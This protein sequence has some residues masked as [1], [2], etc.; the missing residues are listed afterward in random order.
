ML[1]ISK[2]FVHA[3]FI[4][5]NIETG[6][7]APATPIA[8]LFLNNMNHWRRLF[9]K[10]KEQIVCVVVET[11]FVFQNKKPILRQVLSIIR[12]IFA[13]FQHC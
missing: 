7:D 13:F 2:Q 11:L 1:F 12:A 8:I 3:T 4:R 6:V 5:E 9:L 10:R